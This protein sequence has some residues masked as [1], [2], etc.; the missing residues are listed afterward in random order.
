MKLC[1]LVTGSNNSVLYF[2]Y[3]PK[4]PLPPARTPIL[5]PPFKISLENTLQKIKMPVH[6]HRSYF[7]MYTC[8]KLLSPYVP[9]L[10]VHVKG[11]EKLQ[12]QIRKRVVHFLGS[13]GGQV[14]STLVQ[15]ESAAAYAARAVAWDSRPR[16]EVALPFQDMKPTLYLGACSRGGG[17][18][19]G[20]SYRVTFVMI[21]CGVFLPDCFLPRVCELATSSSDRQTKVSQ[22]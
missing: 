13:L 6:L 10:P 14:S 1:V 22:C 8:V 2:P 15:S 3:T 9:P 19:V 11:A 16:L 20:I 12:H 7:S 4:T 5:F 18:V 17:I 21:L